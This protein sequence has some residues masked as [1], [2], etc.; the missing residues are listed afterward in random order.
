MKR[1]LIIVIVLITMHNTISLSAQEKMIISTFSPPDQMIITV[2][3]VVQEAYKRLG[4]EIEMHYLP[5]ARAIDH[6]NEGETDG[7]LYRMAGINKTYPNLLMVPIPVF[8]V[9]IV[10]FTKNTH[11]SVTGW[12]SVSPYKIGFVRGIKFIEEQT[13]GMNVEPVTRDEQALRMLDAGRVD[14]VIEDR[15]VGLLTITDLNLAG[16]SIL[17]PPLASFP[18][19][20]YINKKHQSL[21]PKLKEVFQQMEQENFIQRMQDELIDILDPKI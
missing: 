16:I 12:D 4:I 2:E 17:E 1:A 14:L 10:V 15:L 5:G 8:Q 6:A 19:Y 21:L 7:E 11:F 3:K 13:N 20:H 18:L 9:D